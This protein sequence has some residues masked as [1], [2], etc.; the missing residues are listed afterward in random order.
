MSRRFAVADY[1]KPVTPAQHLAAIRKLATTRAKHQTGFAEADA[2]LR[3]A[4]QAA[5][6]DG[7]T[8]PPIADAAGL[9]PE[10]ISTVQV[11]ATPNRR[12]SWPPLA[13]MIRRA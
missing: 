13:R 9:S 10:R 12:G 11:S 3:D 6:A 1:A 2:A 7:L 4:V 8:A 5:F